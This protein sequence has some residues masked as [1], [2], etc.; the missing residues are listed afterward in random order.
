MDKK[1]ILIV[2]SNHI[3]SIELVYLRLLKK[4]GFSVTLYPAQTIFF[5]YYFHSFVNKIFYRLGFSCIISKIQADLKLYFY[6]FQPNIVIIFKGMEIT[7]KTISWLKSQRVSLLNYNPDH[8]F[9]FSGRGSGNRNVRNSISY[10]DCYFTYSEYIVKQLSSLGFKSKVIPFAFNSDGFTY[11][12]LT[13]AEE[14]LKTCFLGNADR[15]RVN[16]LNSLADLGL[17]ID[18]YG[19]NWNRYKLNNSICVYPA[20]YGPQFWEILKKYAVQLN[21]L[22]PHNFDSHNMRSFDIPGSGGIMLAPITS[23]HMKYFNVDHEV[24]LFD[25]IDK[26]FDLANY[27]LS[28][29]FEQRLSIRNSARNSA[30][31]NNT[32]SHRINSLIKYLEA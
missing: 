25:S 27:I 30:L 29:S 5:Q 8:P 14:I 7:P 2:G 17:Q 3:A 21:L 18:V 16:F 32:Y 13:Q 11:S 10:F 9:I 1:K 12:E 26:D 19:E 15:V 6:K 4:S 24:F 23:D 22:R 28:L 31:R 20:K